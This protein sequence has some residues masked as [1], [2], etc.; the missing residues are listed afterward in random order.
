MTVD[1][2]LTGLEKTW[3]PAL[4]IHTYINFVLFG[5]AAVQFFLL[6]VDA[7]LS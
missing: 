5:Q 3:I 6:W 2:V 7:V 4:Y 1:D